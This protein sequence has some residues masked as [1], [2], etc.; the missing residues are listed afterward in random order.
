MHVRRG[1]N[2]FAG[3]YVENCLMGIGRVKWIFSLLFYC[4]KYSGYRK[5]RKISKMRSLSWYKSY[6]SIWSCLNNFVWILQIEMWK[7][8]SSKWQGNTDKGV[9]YVAWIQIVWSIWMMFNNESV[10]SETWNSGQYTKRDCNISRPPNRVHHFNERVMKCG[11]EVKR[12]LKLPINS[13]RNKF[14]FVS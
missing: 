11:S 3:N 10:Y 2:E 14:I 9:T 8:I 5:Y 4:F 12:N 7:N 13:F 6:S 1:L